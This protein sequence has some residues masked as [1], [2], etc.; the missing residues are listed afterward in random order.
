MKYKLID[1]WKDILS[2]GAIGM[3]AGGALG[4]VVGLYLN[5]DPNETAGLGVIIGGT[6]ASKYATNHYKH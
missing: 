4:Y 1:N 3:A 2:V 6:L 5:R